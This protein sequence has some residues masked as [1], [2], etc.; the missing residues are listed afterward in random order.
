MPPETVR[1]LLFLGGVLVAGIAG[2]AAL[3]LLPKPKWLDRLWMALIAG[4]FVLVIGGLVI[5]K[6][7]DYGWPAVAIFVVGLF[8]AGFL[9]GWPDADSSRR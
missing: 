1:A 6:A 9:K 4:A 8:V 7:Q 2:I 5:V 3:A